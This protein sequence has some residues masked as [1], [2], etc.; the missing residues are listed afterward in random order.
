MPQSPPDEPTTDPP[1]K[2]G[3]IAL[4]LEYK[5]YVRITNGE[6]A[7]DHSSQVAFKASHPDNAECKFIPSEG[8]AIR[9]VGII[10]G[11][12]S[13]AYTYRKVNPEHLCRANV[14]REKFETWVALATVGRI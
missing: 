1:L 9:M 5:E 8:L 13:L 2:V 10:D 14:T 7:Y 12:P 4:D 3:D 6:C 11:I